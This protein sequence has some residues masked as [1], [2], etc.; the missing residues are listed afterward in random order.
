MALGSILARRYSS[1]SENVLDKGFILQDRRGAFGLQ[2][3]GGMDPSA[4]RRNQKTGFKSD[5]ERMKIVSEKGF[6]AWCQ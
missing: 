2:E 5:Q 1:K 4:S 3:I 6:E